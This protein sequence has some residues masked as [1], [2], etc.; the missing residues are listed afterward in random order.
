MSADPRGVHT[1][2]DD[3]YV[4]RTGTHQRCGDFAV[5]SPARTSLATALPS[6]RIL[7]CSGLTGVSNVE[8]PVRDVA[9]ER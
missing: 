7:F 8:L 6:C 3:E 4:C 1:T 9:E 5:L 2:G